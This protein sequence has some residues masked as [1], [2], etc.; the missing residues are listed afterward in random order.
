VAAI[1]VDAD[2]DLDIVLCEYAGCPGTPDSGRRV[3]IRRNDGDATFLAPY[4]HLVSGFPERVRGAD[5]D[6]DGRMDLLVTGNSWIDVSLGNGDGTFQP[7]LPARCDWAPKGFCVADLDGDGRLDL[8]TTNFGDLGSGGESVSILLGNGDGTC[9]APITRPLSYSH[10]FGGVRDIVAGDAD[11]DGDLDLMAGNYG[12]LDVSYFENR[13]AGS[14]A[15]QR[16]YGTGWNTL[17]LV[18]GDFT[19][20]RRGDLLAQVSFGSGLTFRPGLVLLR[21]SVRETLR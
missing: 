14:F 7:P 8:A 16:R 19:G 11:G 1:D 3:F 12:S 13:G 18:F 20:D 10:T 2:R 17:D 6:G 21:A 4:V 15:A 9:R 5:V